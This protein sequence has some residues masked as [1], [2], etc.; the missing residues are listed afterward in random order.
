[1]VSVELGWIEM[2]DDPDF[3]VLA[4]YIAVF[5]MQKILI[6]SKS[7]QCPFYLTDEASHSVLINTKN[8]GG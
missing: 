2:M 8:K 6:R 7:D 4:P 3:M 1:M 5:I